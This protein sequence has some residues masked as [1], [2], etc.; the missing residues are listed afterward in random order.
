MA[1]ASV[2]MPGDAFSMAVNPASAAACKIPSLALSSGTNAT[3]LIQSYLG[4]SMPGKNAGVWMAS[5]NYLSSGMRER[6]TEFQ[7]LGDGSQY[8][9]DAF[10][11]G[12]GYSRS[13]SR[14][15]SCGMNLNLVREQLS[16]YSATAVT[17]D[18]GFLY[19]TDW[20][21]LSFAVGL[22]HFG[23]NSTGKG[24][25]L[26]VQYNRNQVTTEAYGAPTLFSMGVS[27]KAWELEKHQL[28]AAAQLNH[29]NDNAENIRLGL[30]YSFDSLFHV[31]LGYKVNVAGEGLTAGIGIRSRIGAFPL[32][33]DYAIVPNR[34]L[35]MYHSLGL[36]IGF[37]KPGQ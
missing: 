3:G 16:Q 17:A 31:R 36:S 6:R 22:Q 35:G 20:K 10:K 34:Y 26:A 30:H 2:A 15:F 14:M 11:V 12:L 32:T 4:F 19:K 18:L 33:F 5:M 21:D 9:S 37:I 23:G 8:A 28:L 29:P 24:D 1:G 13:L 25:F 27:I 7:P